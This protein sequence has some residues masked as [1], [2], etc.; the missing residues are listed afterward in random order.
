MAIQFDMP[1]AKFEDGILT[2]SLSPPTAIGG[3]DIRFHSQKRFGTITSGAVIKSCSSGFGAGQSGITVVNSGQGIMNIRI[4]EANTSG[5]EFGNYA[6][7][8]QRFSS[9][10]RTVLSQG[11]L[12]LY[13]NIG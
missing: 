9:G 2:V 13:P 10:F 4:N 8:V 7:T 6:A 5:W 1:L 3:W 12:I 11:F